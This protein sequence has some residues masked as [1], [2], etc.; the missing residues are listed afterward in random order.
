MKIL[1]I[2]SEG[3]I[4]QYLIRDLKA[5]G[6]EIA[7]F[8]LCPGDAGK[9]GYR[10]IKGNLLNHEALKAAVTGCD[11]VVNLAAKHH[12][13]GVSR[14]EFF[15]INEEGTRVMLEVM[16]E[17][18]IH[19]FVFF[20][21][22]AVYGD[23]DGESSELTPPDPC[24]DYGASKLAGERLIQD[25]A[26]GNHL[27]EVLI[28][29]PVVVYGPH[30]FANMFRLMDHIYRRRF[31]MVGRGDNIKSTAYV[32]NLTAAAVFMIQR[33]RPGLEVV[34][35]SDIPHRT[36]LEI[37][38]GI[39]QALGRGPVR[40]HFPLGLAAALACPLDIMAR[41]L[42]KNLPVTSLRIKK[43]AQ[44][45]TRHGSSRVRALG[46]RQKVTTEEGLKQMADWYLREGRFERKRC[47]SGARV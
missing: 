22:V 29:R 37:A 1:V 47:A 40:F 17:A 24:N 9:S 43:F 32:E 11:L 27:R 38:N 3:F 42:K 7:G 16:A 25:W 31:L 46:F 28:I 14:E 39:C 26:K 36:S 19:R 33:L 5:A 15:Q 21:S 44:I 13:F 30:N 4:G 12:D 2:G 10:F 45:N 23:V 34:N 6:H 41:I 20:S 8:D 18:G 35:Y